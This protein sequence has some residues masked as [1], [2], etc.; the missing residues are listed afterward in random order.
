MIDFKPFH[1]KPGNSIM[2]II[3]MALF[4]FL[5]FS[6]ESKGQDVVY[7][8][9]SNGEYFSK[10]DYQYIEVIDKRSNASK[11]GEMY[12]S[13]GK[14]HAVKL[15]GSL[16]KEVLDLF[17]EKVKTNSNTFHRIQV[18][19]TQLELKEKFNTTTK[20]YEG[21]I[22]LKLS[23]FLIGK[24]DP[25]PLVDF[26]GSL[27]FRRTANRSD[28][29]RNVVNGIFHKSLEFFD[30]WE[31]AQNLG[32]PSL[33][34]KV[35]LEI[36]DKLRASSRD[37]VFY[38]PTR[39]LV[40]DDFRESPQVTNRFNAAIFTSF[41]MAGTSVVEEGTIVQGLDFKIYMLPKQSW[42][43]TASDYGIAHEQLHFD[44]VRIAVDRLIHRLENM[45]L[46]PEFFQATLNEEFLNA[47]R[48][49]SKFQELY[50]K[51]TRH[52]LDT[53]QQAQWEKRI[54]NALK[55]EWDE[56][57]MVLKLNAIAFTDN[58]PQPI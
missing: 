9:N 53:S 54:K 57:E 33:A 7:E 40:W 42:V 11:I 17:Q 8:L 45:E 21:G 52:G 28:Q 19:V 22:Q 37:T 31:K 1:L 38:T 34:R 47:L 29:I 49:L 26:S 41:S 24:A 27:N 48:E 3:L 50:D 32:N 46:D 10:S 15:N 16:E 30:A 55:G 13:Q 35:R 18:H 5:L 39:S 23:Y 6:N 4:S 56:L 51:Q 44:L 36:T 25:I 20:L 58:L 12:D 43:K 2:R 14:K